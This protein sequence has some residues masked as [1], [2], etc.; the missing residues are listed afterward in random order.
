M[1]T[2]TVENGSLEKTKFTNL[3]E[4]TEFLNESFDIK[5]AWAV[6]DEDVSENDLTLI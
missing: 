4:L 6:S 2:I 1:T 3:Q 5:T